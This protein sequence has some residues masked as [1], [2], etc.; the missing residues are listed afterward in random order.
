MNPTVL[1]ASL[2]GRIWF[3]LCTARRTT[4]HRY[5]RLVF[6]S[7]S[8]PFLVSPSDAAYRVR[9]RPAP[10]SGSFASGRASHWI[11]RSCPGRHGARDGGATPAPGRPWLEASSPRSHCSK[12]R[13]QALA[14]VPVSG[15]VI[16]HRACQRDWSSVFAQAF[17]SSTMRHTDLYGALETVAG[18][19]ASQRPAMCYPLEVTPYGPPSVQRLT[20]A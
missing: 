7:R 17:W 16:Q 9:A 8:H 12:K 6:S 18:R 5:C 14:C 10:S 2:T 20:E 13:V 19:P 4:T 11:L 1:T 15:V 3:F